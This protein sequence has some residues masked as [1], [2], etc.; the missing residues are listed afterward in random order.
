[1]SSAVL[2]IGAPSQSRSIPRIEPG[3]VKRTITALAESADSLPGKLADAE[4]AVFKPYDDAAER[5]LGENTPPSELAMCFPRMVWRI[6]AGLGTLA[7]LGISL[8]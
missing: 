8:L 7:A 6:L 2:A 5:I 4:C 3:V 1:M